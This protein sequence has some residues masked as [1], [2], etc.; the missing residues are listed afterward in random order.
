MTLDR[1]T[2]PQR[3]IERDGGAVPGRCARPL[4]DVDGD[5]PREG[6]AVD[7]LIRAALGTALPC[8]VPAQVLPEQVGAILRL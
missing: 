8:V 2:P 7:V 1:V 5:E 4:T 6:P 3:V